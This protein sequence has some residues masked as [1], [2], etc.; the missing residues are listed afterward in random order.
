MRGGGG[1]G[2]E[3]GIEERFLCQCVRMYCFENNNTGVSFDNMIITILQ[4]GTLQICSGRDGLKL[5]A[6]AGAVDALQARR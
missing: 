1:G 4:A 6:T 5:C 2:R 3:A